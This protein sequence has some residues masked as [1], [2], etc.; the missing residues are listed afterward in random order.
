MKLL[1]DEMWPAQVAV[2]LRKR[3]HDVLAVTESEG[4]RGQADEVVFLHAHQE[5]RAVVTENVIDYRPLAQ[6]ALSQGQ[7][8]AGMIFTSNRAFP[9]GDPRTVGRIVVALASL[10]ESVLDLQ[11]REHWLSQ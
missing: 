7:G 11:D 10:L 5:E 4:L 2:Q 8:H 9:R 1:L 3:G 6:Q